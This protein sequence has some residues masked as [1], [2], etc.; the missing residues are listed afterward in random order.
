MR[1]RAWCFA[2]LIGAISPPLAAQNLRDVP[3]GGRT[4]TMGG[5]GVAAGHDHAMPF[6]NP[7]GIAGT[8]T[9][10]LSISATVYGYAAAPVPDYYVPNRFDPSY[11]TDLRI[12]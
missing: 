2:L 4:A 1:H 10:V 12:S 11:G 3:L 9:D 7:A 5:A 8:P 6:L